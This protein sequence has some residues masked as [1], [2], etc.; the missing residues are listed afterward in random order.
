MHQKGNCAYNLDGENPG[1]L[2]FVI[3]AA[4]LHFLGFYDECGSLT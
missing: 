4:Y 1:E 3:V 2:S